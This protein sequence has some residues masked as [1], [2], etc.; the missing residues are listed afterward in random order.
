M[1]F[2]DPG[3]R[4]SIDG[5]RVLIR[6]EAPLKALVLSVEGNGEEV[7]WSDNGFDVMPD[8]PLEVRAKGLNGQKLKAA[9]MGR[10]HAFVI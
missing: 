1:E 6:V 8:D 7:R 2:P 10:E 3:L 4:V 9:F 5:E